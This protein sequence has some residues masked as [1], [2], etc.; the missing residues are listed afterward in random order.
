MGD[1]EVEISLTPVDGVLTLKLVASNANG[2]KKITVWSRW[3]KVP[4]IRNYEC[5]KVLEDAI[6]PY[7]TEWFPIVVDITECQNEKIERHGPFH[8]DGSN[9]PGFVETDDAPKPPGPYRQT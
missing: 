5:L 6:S 1:S 4:I 3:G 8:S 2:I 9:A 7:P